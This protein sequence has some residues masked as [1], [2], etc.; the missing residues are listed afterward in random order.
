[1]AASPGRAVALSTMPV[2]GRTSLPG[3]ATPNN[4]VHGGRQP[5][6]KSARRDRGTRE[7]EL[8]NLEERW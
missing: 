2:A 6:R 7:V 3:L 5:G 8:S 1:M 4:R